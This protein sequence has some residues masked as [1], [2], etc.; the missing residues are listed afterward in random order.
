MQRDQG[1]GG[2]LRAHCF[3]CG[4]TGD[5]IALGAAVLGL[6]MLADFPRVLA[7]LAVRCGLS[8]GASPPPLPP[9]RPLPPSTPPP[10]DDIRDLWAR[11]GPVC[12]DGALSLAL[13]DRALN[14]AVIADRDLARCLPADGSLPAWARCAGQSWRASGIAIVPL[15][16]AR[17]SLVSLHARTLASNAE[18]KGLSP[19]GHSSAG[20]SH[21]GCVRAGP[22]GAAS[23]HG[24]AR[25]KRRRWLSPEGC[26]TF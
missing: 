11:C 7:E 1:T 23:P 8:A 17:G 14:P 25:A 5:V 3:G 16:D 26:R 6:D 10:A 13:F 24:G 9:L 22:T 19:A 4:R 20:L 18:P 21:G 15:F 2:T 12:N